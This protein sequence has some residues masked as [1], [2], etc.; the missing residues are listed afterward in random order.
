L[1]KLKFVRAQFCLP[2]AAQNIKRLVSFLSRT[3]QPPLQATT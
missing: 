3:P 1:R 2:A